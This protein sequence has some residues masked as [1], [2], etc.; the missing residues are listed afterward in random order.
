MKKA[1]RQMVSVIVPLYYGKKYVGQILK[2]I[3]KNNAYACDIEIQLVF[4]NDCPDEN[5]KIDHAKYNFEIEVINADRNAGIHGARVNALRQAAGE[6]ILF[7]DQDD[8]IRDNYIQSQCQKIGD[9]DAVVCRLIN[10]KR[11]HYTDSFRFEEVITK[12]FMLKNWCP[13]VSPGQVL[14]RKE[15]VS[16]IWKENILKNNGADDYFLWLCMMAEEKRLALNQEVLFE[17][18][19]TGYNTSENT[20]LMM[21]SEEEMIRILER[22]AVF[23]E[24]DQTMFDVLRPSLRHIHVK[25]LDTQRNALNCL[26]R[27]YVDLLKKGYICDW[28]KKHRDKRIAIYGAGEL[29][30][31]LYDFL[32]SQGLNTVCYLDQN[33]KFIMSEIPVY[34][35]KEA[36]IKLDSI[37]LTIPSTSLYENLR[38][39]FN[40]EVVDVR[41]VCW[42]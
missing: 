34:T 41:S 1:Y 37:L 6:Y 31:G 28:M 4:Y 33:A 8:V 20:N 3:E 22:E 26:N 32:K 7:L 18:V 35:L 19:I 2:Q 10:G 25:Q 11:L 17:H 29:G 42:E 21:D 9:A 40:C 13:I 5:I 14:L 38:C 12:E 23:C 39:K 30:T 36:D 16:D 24:R 27:L 15:A